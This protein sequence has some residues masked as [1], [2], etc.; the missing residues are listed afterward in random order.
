MRVVACL[1]I[2]EM[3]STTC[4][5]L[6]HSPV[7]KWRGRLDPSEPVREL[8][9]RACVCAQKLKVYH[10]ITKSAILEQPKLVWIIET[11]AENADK[12]NII[13]LHSTNTTCVSLAYLFTNRHSQ[14]SVLARN[15]SRLGQSEQTG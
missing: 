9:K 13:K 3:F 4:L 11:H 1:R 6:A 5:A 15:S 7:H 12:P 2:A 10:G 14:S 8:T